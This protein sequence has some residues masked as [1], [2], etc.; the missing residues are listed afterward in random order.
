MT[1]EEARELYRT[2]GGQIKAFALRLGSLRRICRESTGTEYE[3][4][5]YTDVLFNI[6]VVV[7]GD[8]EPE[9]VI[10]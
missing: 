6:P 4:S 5:E 2:K 10:V 8:D 1:L 7:V 9:G 3:P